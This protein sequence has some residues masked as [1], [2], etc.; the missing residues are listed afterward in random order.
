MLVNI[1]IFVL[2]DH[3]ELGVADLLRETVKRCHDIWMHLQVDPACNVLFTMQLS[4]DELL[5]EVLV[6]DDVLCITRGDVL[7]VL[8]HAFDLKEEKI[9]Y[10]EIWNEISNFEFKC[11]ERPP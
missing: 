3:G 2:L 1:A 10:D 5:S 7:G 8:A 6:V 4:Q 11:P 9:G